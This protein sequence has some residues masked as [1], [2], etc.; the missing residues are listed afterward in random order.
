M[1]NYKSYL[2]HKHMLLVLSTTMTVQGSHCYLEHIWSGISSV[3]K[4]RNI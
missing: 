1:N 4:I 2:L 3:L